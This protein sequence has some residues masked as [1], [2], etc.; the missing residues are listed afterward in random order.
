M[1]TSKEDLKEQV[2]MIY[3]LIDGKA[4][5]VAMP[6]VDD[7]RAV[8]KFFKVAPDMAANSYK[9]SVTTLCKA[10]LEEL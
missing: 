6:N 7:K 4:L 10:Y 8:R 5:N 2:Q 3:E 9:K 1:A